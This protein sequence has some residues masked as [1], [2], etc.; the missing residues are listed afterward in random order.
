M[1]INKHLLAVSAL[2]ILFVARALAQEQDFKLPAACEQAGHMMGDMSSMGNMDAMQKSMGGHMGEATKAH[3]QA[4]IGMH[5]PMVQGAMAENPDMAFIC[6]MIAHHKGAIA[7]AEVQL[8]YGTDE[9]AKKIAQKTIDEQSKE[10]DQ[11]TKWV[12]E[13]AKK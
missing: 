1:K 12:E 5:P 3:M 8:K 11:M 4:I 13:H 2:S 7:M 9:E 6:S 10:V